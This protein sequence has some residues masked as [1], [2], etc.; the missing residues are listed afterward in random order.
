MLSLT[1]RRTPPALLCPPPPDR[2][3]HDKQ[4]GAESRF[5][6]VWSQRLWLGAAGGGVETDAC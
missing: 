1:R 5:L 2:D 4:E 3:L 6:F